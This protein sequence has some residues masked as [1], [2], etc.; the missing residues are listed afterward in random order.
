M[1]IGIVGYGKMGS[2]I[3][4]WLSSKPYDI[5]ILN[6]SE[7]K[8]RDREEK[9]F[10]GLERSLKKGA[11][12]EEMFFKKKDSIKFI[13][14]WEDLATADIIIETA[15]ESYEEKVDILR[16]LESVMGKNSVLVTNT[17][18]YSIKALANELRYKERFCGLHFFYPVFIIDL[19]EIIKWKDDQTELVSYL[20]DFCKQM[21]KKSIVVMDQPGSIINAILGYPYVEALYILEEGLALPS[22]IDEIAR[23][24]FYIAPCESIDIVGIDFFIEVLKTA[25][26][27]GGVLPLLQEGASQ[28]ELSEIDTGGRGGF[29]VPKLFWRLLSEN[30][31]GKKVSKGLYLYQGKKPVDDLPE[32]YIDPDRHSPFGNVSERNKLIAKRLLYSIFNGSIF[33][34]Q[35][36]MSSLPEIDL[37]MK[38]VLHMKE[39]P[40]TMMRMIGQ[41]KVKEDFDFLTQSFGKR[42]KQTT[43]EFFNQ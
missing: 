23:W 13:H 11:I 43:F 19:V 29:H 36:G 10:K 38:E 7:E 26:I 8:A 6:R 3:F 34:F 35:K 4:K 31:L 39:G 42:F 21:G 9:F 27:P 17:S 24:S 30:R 25:G 14:R 2:G 15:T 40:F 41:K 33:G 18:S 28:V 12:S 16:R 5:N 1:N 37:G 20:K 32:F 22:I